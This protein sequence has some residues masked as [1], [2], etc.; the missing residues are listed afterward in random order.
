MTK[1]KFC[2]LTRDEDIGA[3]NRLTPDFAGLVFTEKSRRYVS[4]ER[5]REIREKLDRRIKTVGVFVNA[6][7]S[8]IVELLRDGVIDIAQLHGG[9]DDAYIRELRKVID[10]PV[11][12]A[13]RIDSEIDI[14]RAG[15][16]A[17]DMVLLDSG[18]GGTGKRIDWY[19]AD[20]MTRP[21]FLAGGLTPENAGDAVMTLHPFAL[22]VSSGI[23]TDGH[24]NEEKMAAFM[25]AVKDADRKQKGTE[26]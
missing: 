15:A 5:A 4:P 19:L 14:L 23:E 10:R 17:A 25:N 2:G 26:K 12:K 18:T 1:V 6:N 22:D 21:Y 11:I 7:I 16:S 13:F 3:A 24:K 8:F 9:E 20:M